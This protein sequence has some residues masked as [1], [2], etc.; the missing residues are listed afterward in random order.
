M[1]SYL[2]D[3]ISTFHDLEELFVEGLGRPVSDLEHND[4]QFLKVEKNK[5]I[6]LFSI[7]PMGE[8]WIPETS[9]YR[10]LK[11]CIQMLKLTLEP[12]IQISMS[13]PVVVSLLYCVL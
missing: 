5:Q 4:M 1:F 9:D 8:I 3:D 12:I 2:K 13:Q 10:T 6:S 11:S 7:P